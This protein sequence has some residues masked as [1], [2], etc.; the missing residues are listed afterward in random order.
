MNE[1]FVRR[2]GYDAIGDD[3]FKALHGLDSRCP[4]CVN[5]RVFAGESVRWEVKSPKDNHWFYITNFLT[6]SPDGE[7]LKLSIIQDITERKELE[8]MLKRE[9]SEGSL[10]QKTQVDLLKKDLSDFSST[11]DLLLKESAKTLHVERISYW[12]FDSDCTQI[13][14]CRRYG[15]SEDKFFDEETIIDVASF[16][17][18]F[19]ALNEQ[20]I[21]ATD[22][23]QSC[24]LT[25]EFTEGYLKPLGITSMLDVPIWHRGKRVGIICHEHIGPVRQWSFAEKDFCRF[26][27]E[28]LTVS[29]E[30]ALKQQLAVELKE[31]KLRLEVAINGADLGLWELDLE[32]KK[33]RLSGQSSMLFN[34]SIKDV[35]V[36]LVD[37]ENLIH[38]EDLCAWRKNIDDYLAAV[39][40]FYE[41]EY[42]VKLNSDSWRWILERGRISKRDQFSKPI[43]ISGTHLDITDR[44][45]DEKIIHD[46]LAEKE[47]LLKEI[48]HRVKN[49]L[50]L[51]S[52]LLMLQGHFTNDA[53]VKSVLNVAESR[54]QSIAFVHEKLHQS[55]GLTC[56]KVSEYVEK[57]IEHYQQFF[58]DL[59][60]RINIVTDIQDVSFGI[61]TAVPIGFIISELIMNC[62]KHAFPDNRQGH[63]KISLEQLKDTE[64]LLEVSDDGV[65]FPSADNGT[66]KQSLGF[67]LISI[68][69][70]QLDGHFEKA[71][72]H[73]QTS[74]KVRFFDKT[75]R[76]C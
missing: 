19:E 30:T 1:N 55:K 51:I 61:D 5:D 6:H 15:L 31:S 74:V 45:S 76:F 69:T 46:N 65:G 66:L 57:I 25:S 50:Q 71:S 70:S 32:N 26:V 33:I 4:W 39:S 68:F 63:I 67:E 58:K 10:F 54:I 41:S 73:G 8:L 37:W 13:K 36:L 62:F 14:C 38:K 43:R 34:Q 40:A 49:N 20:R 22:N 64:H 23:A 29:L 44:K 2:T 75:T 60:D 27:S 35:E 53:A 9:A 42:R 17:K 18:Y 28:M 52:S 3:C 47:A 48:H 11:L 16:P 21:I 24:E 72:V 56:F 59:G 7:P 12:A